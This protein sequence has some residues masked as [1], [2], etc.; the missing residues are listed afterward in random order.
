[1]TSEQGREPLRS[2][3]PRSPP[4][5]SKIHG[6][7]K[8]RAAIDKCHISIIHNEG[9]AWDFVVKKQGRLYSFVYIANSTQRH[10][11]ELLSEI[12]EGPVQ[13][14]VYDSFFILNE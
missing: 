6:V 7:K 9:Y 2:N 4:W 10:S 12:Y 11:V 14:N 1:M 3:V 5:L 13:L 8:I